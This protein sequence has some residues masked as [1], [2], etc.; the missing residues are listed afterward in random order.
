M[1]I[2]QLLDNRK[3]I[4]SYIKQKRF[5]LV[6]ITPLVNTSSFSLQTRQLTPDSFNLL[7]NLLHS[8]FAV[9]FSRGPLD[10]KPLCLLTLVAWLPAKDIQLLFQHF[11]SRIDQSPLLQCLLAKIRKNQT[12]LKRLTLRKGLFFTLDLWEA[13]LGWLVFFLEAKGKQEQS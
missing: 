11:S 3:F 4:T 8:V 7:F 6:C 5:P 13:F 1:F 12:L 2:W 10:D 9:S